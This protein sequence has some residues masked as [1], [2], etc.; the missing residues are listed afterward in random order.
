MSVRTLFL[1]WQDKDAT[2]KWYPV[3]RLDTDVDRSI[4]RFRYTN[5]AK[6][7]VEEVRY[8][9]ALDFPVLEKDYRASELFPLFSNRVI[10][11][12]R[13]D[14][15][16]YLSCL[17]LPGSA[18]PIEILSANGGHR[19]TDWYE[20]FPQLEKGADGSFQCRFFLHGSSHVNCSAQQRVS[21]LEPDDELYLALELTNP[22]APVAVQVQTTDYF[23]IGWAPRYLVNDL[24]T[25]M[26]KTPGNYR[27]RVVR[28]NPD[29]APSK[30]RL[31]VEMS[32]NFGS[33]VPMAD[34]DFAPIVKD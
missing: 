20:V 2:R 13:P 18:D 16:T 11:Q 5:G 31:L 21:H 33:H 3:G 27:A 19:V 23:M 30:Q 8:P 4:Y 26:A 14:R 17:D 9:L 25:A 34:Q 12:G 6:R 22:T 10:A 28:V 32:G 1:A 7:A 15:P 24:T 29:P